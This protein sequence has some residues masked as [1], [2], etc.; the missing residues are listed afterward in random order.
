M[1]N[2]VVGKRTLFRTHIS[3]NIFR[4]GMS[5]IIHGQRQLKTTYFWIEK[6]K[7]RNCKWNIELENLLC[8][9]LMFL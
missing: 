4:N 9:D 3:V 7:N 5:K 8:Y 1:S 2:N 6:Y